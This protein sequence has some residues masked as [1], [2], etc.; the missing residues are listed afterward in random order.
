MVAFAFW[1]IIWSLALFATF[2][3]SP[4]YQYQATAKPRAVATFHSIGL[5]YSPREAGPDNTCQVHYKL[6]EETK[7]RRGLDLWYDPNSYEYRGSLVNLYPGVTYEIMLTLGKTNRSR[8][9][10]AT[11]WKEQIPVGDIIYLPDGITASPYVVRESGTAEAYRLFTHP[12]G[13]QTIID[14]N[15]AYDH[16]LI[17]EA[18]Y[19]IIRG[20]TLK[21]AGIH[22]IKILNNAHDVIIEDCDISGWGRVDTDGFGV[23]EDAGIFSDSEETQRIIIQRNRIHHPRSDTN[24]WK[25]YRQ[26]YST[27]HPI[28]PKAIV[29]KASAGN[30]VIRYNEIFSDDDHYFNDGIGESKNFD[31]G[32]PNSDTDIYSN[33]IE[34]CWDDAIES[35]GNNRNVRIWNNYIDRVYIGIACVPVQIGPVYIWRNVMH[36]SRK[37]PLPHHNTGAALLKLGGHTVNNTFYGDG[38]IYIFHNTSLIPTDPGLSGHSN[39]INAANRDLKNCVTRNNILESQRAVHY[40]ILDNL[41][42]PENDFDY[43][44][45]NG[46]VIAVEGSERN[47]IKGN[48]LYTHERG[49]DSDSGTG[50]FY[51]KSSSPGY[52]AGA[53]IPNFNDNFTGEAPDMGAHEAQSGAMAFGV[54]ANY[55][56]AN[57]M[58]GYWQ[59]D[60]KKGSSIVID[61]SGMG[62]HGRVYGSPA[63]NKGKFGSAL[64]M[65]GYEDYV[66]ILDDGESSL[67]VRKDLSISVWLKTN[68]SRPR[69]EWFISKPGSYGWKVFN[70]KPIFFINT[71]H[72]NIIEATPVSLNEWHHLVAI[73]DISNQVV[74]IYIDGELITTHPVSGEIAESDESLVFGHPGYD[75]L[76]GLIDNV[77]IYN[78]VL[79]EEEII[80]LFHEL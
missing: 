57:G 35:E 65:S 66:E 36:S 17:I 47:G 68:K 16:C 52:D 80:D 29:L 31:I 9:I 12:E 51:L 7:W 11:T 53:L 28:G 5:Y 79:V 10:R 45:Y 54:R 49:F 26:K 18:S 4:S 33:Y 60:E 30:H 2:G 21:N 73:Y 62:N 72:L 69:N 77:Q 48:P 76:K 32:F 67:D 56:N 1:L 37:G 23:N 14:V 58:M 40:A 64:N 22:A 25:E 39:Q 70:H 42:N 46:A 43:D 8:T 41:E 71:P 6:L 38:K 50:Y 15:N 55:L 27:Y 20:L 24:S 13:T 78:R 34:R 19:V 75:G 74:K 61:K 59:F 63:R 44:L 3:C